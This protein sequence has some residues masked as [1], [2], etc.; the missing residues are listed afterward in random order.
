MKILLIS[1]NEAN[2]SL[3]VSALSEEGLD[4]IHYRCFL[5]ALDNIEEILPDLILVD[6]EDFPRQWKILSQYVKSLDFEKQ[7]NI[8]L[9]S[10]RGFSDDDKEKAKALGIILLIS[11]EDKESLKK[12]IMNLENKIKSDGEVAEVAIENKSLIGD[13]S[14]YSVDNLLFGEDILFTVDNLF[15]SLS[16][17]END[18]SD[19]TDESISSSEDEVAEEEVPTVSEI[20]ESHEKSSE[21]NILEDFDLFT[22]DNLFGKDDF[23]LYSVISLYDLLS[24]NYNGREDKKDKIETKLEQEINKQRDKK[25]TGSLLHR[26]MEFY[27]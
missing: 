20:L 25:L 24:K 18:K 13:F 27:E 2:S 3:L 23:Q 4:F 1:E 10:P 14:L 16:F 7:I 12:E 15:D 8:A 5:K 19:E 26:I 17:S 9:Y 11:S 21:K 6:A 22:V